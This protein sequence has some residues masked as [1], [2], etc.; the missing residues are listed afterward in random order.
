MRAEQ[1]FSLCLASVRAD[2]E[3]QTWLLAAV[4]VGLALFAVLLAIKLRI[5]TALSEIVVGTVAQLV[6][7]AGVGTAFLGAQQPWITFLAGAGAIV[8]TFLA[9]AEL[10]PRVFRERWKEATVVGFVSFLAPFLGC[11]AVAAPSRLVAASIMAGGGCTVDN[12]GRGRLRGH[13]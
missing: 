3:A 2:W 12:L 1:E 10:D 6:I 4:W 7:G 8:L 5:S 9:G 11:T 13:A